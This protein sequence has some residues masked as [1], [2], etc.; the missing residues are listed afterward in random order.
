MNPAAHKQAKERAK[1]AREAIRDCRIC[2]RDC[3]VDRTAGQSGYCGLGDKLRSFREMLFSEEEEGLNPSF[4]LHFAGCNLRCE[5]CTVIE[6]NEQPAAADETDLDV[7]KGRIEERIRQGARTMSLLGGEPAVNIYGILELLSRL[8]CKTT[9]IWNSNMYYNDIINELIEGL[10]DVYLADIKVGNNRCAEKILGA[11]DYP[12]VV[13]KNILRASGRGRLLLRHVILPGHTECCL[14][15]I[16]HWIADEIP[17]AELSLRTN[18]VPPAGAKAAPTG[19]LSDKEFENAQQIA[20]KLRL[21]L[22]K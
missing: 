8:D 18:Y 10:A 3:G 21:N 5:H 11:A 4:L 9:V 12:E 6:W 1:I 14:K 16:L 2:P 7:L 20:T 13:K 19:Y 17:E 22:V 15:P